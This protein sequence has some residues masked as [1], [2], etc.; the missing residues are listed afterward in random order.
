MSK[1]PQ[2]LN[3]ILFTLFLSINLCLSL[4]QSQQNPNFVARLSKYGIDFFGLIGHKLV[5]KELPKTNFP[6]ILLPIDDGPGSGIF[7]FLN[8]YHAYSN[9][10]KYILVHKFLLKLKL[11]F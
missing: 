3:F 5:N 9:I 10:S 6:D 8:F 7:L 1:G 2:K 11:S 4:S